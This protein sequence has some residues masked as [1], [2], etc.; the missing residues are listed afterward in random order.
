[1]PWGLPYSL[2]SLRNTCFFCAPITSTS[3]TISQTH[4]ITAITIKHKFKPSNEWRARESG[5]INTE[6]IMFN[7]IYWFWVIKYLSKEEEKKRTRN[8]LLPIPNGLCLVLFW[9]RWCSLYGPGQAYRQRYG[10]TAKSKWQY[11]EWWWR[12][13]LCFGVTN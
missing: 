8:S 4:L 2:L 3:A 12:K 7:T 10:D 1:M 5:Q 6:R 11:N 13:K 9:W